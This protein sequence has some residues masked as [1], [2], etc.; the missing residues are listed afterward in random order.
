MIQI[1]ISEAK[2]EDI[3]ER[4]YEDFIQ[5]TKCDELEISDYRDNIIFRI[6]K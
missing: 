5:D 2:F 4:T 3:F 1:E 6:K